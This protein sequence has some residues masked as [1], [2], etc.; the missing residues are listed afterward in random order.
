MSAILGM[1]QAGA[2]MWGQDRQ[3]RNQQDLMN[4]QMRNQMGLNQQGSDLQYQQW[5]RTNYPK[6]VEMMKKAGLNPALMYKGAGPGGQTGSQTGGSATGGQAA[7]MNPMDIANLSLVEAQRDKLRAEANALNS[8]AGSSDAQARKLNAD[9][10]LSELEGNVKSI[11]N[12]EYIK[13]LLDDW[14]LTGQESDLKEI[15]L[16]LKNNGIH[17]D[18][19]ATV[20]GGLSGWDLTKPGVL[21]EKVDFLPVEVTASL[22]ALGIDFNPGMTKRAIMN[23]VIGGFMAGKIALDKMDRIIEAL[24]PRNPIGFKN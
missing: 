18:L 13:G 19:I 20:V 9:A 2:N 21:N 16:G 4:Q 22:K 8:Q 5:L 14:K 1:I 12:K 24:T 3:R 15:A 23:S 11:F 10:L 17:N 7:S 6:Q